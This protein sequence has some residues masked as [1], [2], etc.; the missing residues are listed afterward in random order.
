MKKWQR[1]ISALLC[2][3][4]LAALLPAAALA[5]SDAERIG[6]LGIVKKL[7]VGLIGL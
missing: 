6:Y 7:A 5:E 4:L 1:Y 2:V 3:L